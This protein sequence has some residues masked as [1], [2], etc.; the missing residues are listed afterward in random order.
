MVRTPEG[1]TAAARHDR[2]PFLESELAERREAGYPPFSR[3][4]NVTFWGKQAAEV[5]SLS[6]AFAAELRAQVGAKPGWEVLG[7][8]DCVKARVKDQVRRHVMVKAPLNAPLGAILNNCAR[9][10][11]VNRGCSMSIDVDAYDM[12]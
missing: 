8:A 1:L 5:A 2:A 9:T 6:N 10:L 4:G 12:M 3:L 7:P 11:P